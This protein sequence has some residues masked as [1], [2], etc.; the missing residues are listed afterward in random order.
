MAKGDYSNIQL[1]MDWY[2]GGP[3]EFNKFAEAI[4]DVG[5]SPCMEFDC[6][7]Q[8]TCAMEGVECKAFRFW[9]NNGSLTTMRKVN[10]KK[11]EVSIEDDCQRILRICE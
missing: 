6:P 2:W 8:K 10:G 9:V 1:D 7:R 4:T 3:N 5:P 11:T